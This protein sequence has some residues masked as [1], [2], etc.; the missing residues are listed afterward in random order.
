MSI[1]VCFNLDSGYLGKKTPGTTKEFIIKVKIVDVHNHAG[2]I[3]GVFFNGV[4]VWFL[5]GLSHFV[6]RCKH[7]CKLLWLAPSCH[8]RIKTLDTIGS[9]QGSD[10]SLGVS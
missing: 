3:S 9:C 1:H 8:I 10:F 4:F 2:V 6:P 7:F 5:F